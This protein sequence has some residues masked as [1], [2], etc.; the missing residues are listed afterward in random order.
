MTHATRA[1]Q[2]C[3][4]PYTPRQRNQK[5]CSLACGKKGRDKY[6]PKGIRSKD[7]L[8]CGRAFEYTRSD[9]Q[10]CGQRCS[11]RFR[12]GTPKV[13]LCTGCGGD[14]S[15]RMGNAKF[16]APC[17]EDRPQVHQEARKQRLA[18]EAECAQCLE[19]YTAHAP[20]Q[21]F[22]SMRCSLKA[23]RALQLSVIL[24]KEC[25]GCGEEFTTRDARVVA[26]SIACKQ[27]A[28]KYPGKTRVLMAQCETCG[29][30]FEGTRAG[31]RFC[32]RRCIAYTAKHKR[33]ALERQAYVEPVSRGAIMERDKWTCKLCGDRI[34]KNLTGHHPKAPSLDHIIP[35][36]KGGEHSRANVQ[37]AHF[38]CNAAKGNR[39][40]Q[41]QLML[42]G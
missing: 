32:S 40:G 30:L 10:F 31:M 42:F 26:C 22:C 17:Y 7:C 35:L 4:K 14:I 20:E 28:K 9:A 8:Q 11:I 36:S 1:C 41:E 39:G 15:D 23:N 5:Y 38:G 37:A 13:R 29:V 27:W 24:T 33:R 19:R 3:E 6:E 12:K 2:A 34:P 18:R 21:R 25:R 16:C